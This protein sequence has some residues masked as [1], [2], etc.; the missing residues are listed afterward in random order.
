MGKYDDIMNLPHWEPRYHQR[1][2][3]H[4]RAGQFAAFAALTGY[5]SMVAETSR[6]TGS[7]IELDEEQMRLL[8]E[9]VME[10]SARISDHPRILIVHFVKDQRKEGGEYVTTQG[11]VRNVELPNRRLIMKDGMAICLDDIL[12]ISLL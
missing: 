7:R 2:P 1:M 3:V 12:R 9:A 5:D 10:I 6:L 11:E 4:D 8:N